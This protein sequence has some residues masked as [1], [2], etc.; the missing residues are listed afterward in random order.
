MKK[1]LMYISVLFVA[2]SVS[3]CVEPFE[4]TTS[5]ALNNRLLSLPKIAPDYT[6]KGIH[7]AQV[8]STG[9]W[10][11]YIETES[12]V[13]WCYFLASY[14]D[15]TTGEEIQVVEPLEYNEEGKIIKVRGTGTVFVP[16]EYTDNGG[17]VERVA[18]ITATR[19]DTGDE[20]IM[21]IT[22]KK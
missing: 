9:T 17:V 3:S 4:Y 5:L 22:Q 6:G 21:K 19:E 13:Q 15:N 10:E 16:V 1:I 14:T 12:N 2:M 11:L 8:T 18:Y 7:Y 20:C